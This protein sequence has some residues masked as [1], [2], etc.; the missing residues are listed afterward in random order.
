MRLGVAT[1]ITD[2][3]IPPIALALVLEERGHE[4]LWIAEHTHIPVSRR[5]PFRDDEELPEMYRRAYDPIVALTAAAAVT[6]QLKVATAVCLVAERDPIVLAKQVACV[7]RLSEGRFIL[8]AGFGW[9]LEEMENH[10]VDPA[11]SLDARAGEDRRDACCSGPRTKPSTQAPWCI[12][13]RVGV[14]RSQ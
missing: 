4:S 12:S 13:R 2:Q 14:G 9:N 5:S 3:S 1:F 6:R 10:G 8:G 7:D 11:S